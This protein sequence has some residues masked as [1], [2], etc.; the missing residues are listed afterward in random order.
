VAHPGDRA[1]KLVVSFEDGQVTVRG[2]D[3]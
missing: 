2:S 3:G 1:S